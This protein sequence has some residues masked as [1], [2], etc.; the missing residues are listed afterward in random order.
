MSE[1]SPFSTSDT[2]LAVYLQYNKHHFVG[3]KDDPH[4]A[5]RK[6]FVFV[7]T[8]ETEELID[9]FHQG[10]ALVEPRHLLHCSKILI[11]ELNKYKDAQ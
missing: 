3:F 10:K 9:E 2:A 8:D 7:K 11:K 4:D 6:I 1:L 5:R